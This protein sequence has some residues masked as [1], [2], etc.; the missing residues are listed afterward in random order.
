MTSCKPVSFSRRILHPGVSKYCTWI[1]YTGGNFPL[2]SS[3][4]YPSLPGLNYVVTAGHLEWPLNN[5]KCYSSLNSKLFRLQ[6]C[7]LLHIL[8]NTETVRVGAPKSD[9]PVFPSHSRLQNRYPARR[10]SLPVARI[11]SLTLLLL[12]SIKTAIRKTERE[13]ERERERQRD[14]QD[15]DVAVVSN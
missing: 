6:I 12:Y 4:Y 9:A 11:P 7:E 13:R 5:K 14:P 15:R 2:S 3:S 8:L 1:S 10:Q